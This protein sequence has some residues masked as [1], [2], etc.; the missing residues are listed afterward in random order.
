MKLSVI[1]PIYNCEKLICD[2]VQSI[3]EQ[4]FSDFEL[5]LLNDGSTDQTPAVLEKLARTDARIRVINLENG[6]PAKARNCGIEKASGEYLC[7]I[8]SDDLIL[9]EMF[10][11]MLSLAENNHLDMVAC[12]YTME[13][14]STKTPHVKQFSYQSFVAISPD[15]FHRHLTPLIQAHLM[16]VVWNKLYCRELIMNHHIRFPDYLSGEDRLFNT[17]CF[18]LVQSFGFIGQP[19]YR[20]FLRGQKTLAN[21][22][23]PHRYEAAL[24]CHTALIDAYQK[25]GLRSKE[26]D[27]VLDFMFVKG[28]LSCFTQLN[29][30]DC[31]MDRKEKLDYISQILREPLVHKAIG[32]DDKSFGY[33]KYVNQVLRSG[34]LT[35]IYFMAKMIYLMQ[36]RFNTLYLNLKHRL[37]S[38]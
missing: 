5:L 36:F 32:S 12:G 25:M 19:F 10:E 34:N 33:S 3:L 13:N 22:Y 9:P 6:G 21:R 11:K 24:A 28:I 38:S 8:D 15:E 18:P 2:T 16:Y 4:T 1:I 30:K 35:S 7:F 37:K 23:V 31:P 14:L 29:A 20:Y 27:S 26:N 17:A